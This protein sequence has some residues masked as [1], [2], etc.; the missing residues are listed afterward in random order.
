MIF[1]LSPPNEAARLAQLH[2]LKLLDTP[3]DPAFDQLVEL[4]R[5]QL[6]VPIALISLVDADRQW[7]KAKV[8]I[9]SC[10]TGRDVSFCGHV[11][12]DNETLVVEDA[13]QDPRFANNPLVTGEPKIR[14]YAGVPLVIDTEQNPDLILGTLCIVDTEPRTI[15]AEQLQIL[16]LLAKQAEQ[17]LLLHHQRLLFN[18]QAMLSD[19]RLAQYDAITT[20]AA[21]GI[22]RIN[23]EGTIQDIN[24]YALKLLGYCSD[25]VLGKNVN[26]LMPDKWAKHHDGYLDN[27][28]TSGNKKIIGKGRRVAALHKSQYQI[29]VHLAVERVRE[30][31]ASDRIEFIGILT[32][33][34]EEVQAEQRERAEHALLRSIINASRDPIFAKNTAGDYLIANRAFLD[35]THKTVVDITEAAIFE[36]IGEEQAQHARE[37]EQRVMATGQPETMRLTINGQQHF[38]VTKSP[39]IDSDGNISGV[40][41]VTHNVNDL[42][43]TSK[44]LA[45][46][47]Q[48]LSVLH[49]GL[50]DYQALM[51]GNQLWLFLQEALRELTGSDYSL[52]GEVLQEAEQAV[53][54]VHAISDLSWSQAARDF[55]E[56]LQ[57]DDMR[58]TNAN[59]LL[60]KVFSQGQVVLSNSLDHTN[61]SDTFLLN[62]S[63]LHNYLGVPIWDD[64]VV[65]GMYAIAN[66]ALDYNH[67]LVAWLEPFTSTCALLIKLYRQ[68]HERDRFTEQ[69]Q[70]A[71]DT[72]EQASRAKS[73]FLS[74]MSHELRTP[75][76]AIMGFAQLLQ[77]NK[78]TP[79]NDRQFRQV[80]QIYKSGDHLLSLINEVLDLARIEAGSMSM[81][82]EALTPLDVIQD[83]CSS[84]SPIAEQHNVHL[85]I[86]HS[87]M[88]APKVMAD[89]TRLK[90]VLIN[91]ISNAIKYNLPNGRVDISCKAQP[92]SLIISVVDTGVGIDEQY[93]EQLFE[94]FNR[95]GADD[96][97]IEGAGVGLAITKN[98]IEQMHGYISIKNN[99]ASAGCEFWFTLPLAVTG[100]PLSKPTTTIMKPNTEATHVPNGNQAQPALPIQRRILYVEDNPANQRLMADVLA[101]RAD[102]ALEF[103]HSAE[104][105]FEQA[106][107]APPELIIMDINLPGMNGFDALRLF[108]RHPLTCTIPVVALSANATT[109]DIERAHA[110]GFKD[111]LTKPFDVTQLLS[112]LDTL[113]EPTH[114]A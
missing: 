112:V 61:E 52:I 59:S 95:L 77:S 105:A 102:I 23:G 48:L 85:E 51:S 93:L 15:S 40:V 78:R 91:L 58:L 39:L 80:E 45:R 19:Y 63:P 73:D 109:E 35:I 26:M 13:S 87:V 17:L 64:G 21:A 25:E 54:K 96:S 53:L 111:Y 14:F 56:S 24:D 104:L 42:L 97:G 31:H 88:I 90:Q 22:I 74:S 101:E 47:Q 113:L 69:L 60:G 8:G 3:A 33:L 4:T 65:I 9:D 66:S 5:L 75:L 29:P 79:L 18:N 16:T 46:Q 20:G 89:Y 84:L 86:A 103:T 41:S 30:H 99:S 2:E 81:S 57:Q 27:H 114:H 28:L 32:D 67:D 83:A 62:N 6:Q 10:E 100:S 106:C 72:A 49:R 92:D 37:C 98:I 82:I 12:A 71:R 110:A 38:D 43:R 76:N 70:L 44:E 55:M 94:P 68:L 50:T 36:Q 34:T 1:P 7:F 11:V 107:F 108:S